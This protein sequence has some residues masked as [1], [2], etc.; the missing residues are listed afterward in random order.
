MSIEIGNSSGET[1]AVDGIHDAARVVIRPTDV[2]GA[3][4]LSAWNSAAGVAAGAGADSEIFAFRNPSATKTAIVKRIAISM[5]TGATGF[6]AGITTF[7]AKVA[8]SFTAAPTDGT[9]V[10]LTTDNCKMATGHATAACAAYIADA[11]VLTSGTETAD[12]TAFAVMHA[13]TSN[14]TLTVHVDGKILYEPK[15]GAQPLTLKQDEGFIIY[16]IVPATG[17]WFVTVTVE[18]EELL[19]ADY[20]VT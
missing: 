17:V 1:V 13:T 6:T 7:Y 14:A 20:P 15:E 9:T 3:Y 18:W 12:A 4:R 5:H 8:R 2:T 19:N 10:T 11:S 16:A